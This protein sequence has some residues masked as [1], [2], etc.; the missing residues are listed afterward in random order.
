MRIL[1]MGLPGSGKTTLANR[2]ADKLGAT[3]LNADVIRKEYDDWDFSVE[4]RHRQAD[5]MYMLS[6]KACTKY[7]V[8]DFVCPLPECRK[9]I[10]AQ[11]VIW[12]NTIKEGRFDDTNQMFVQ[13]TE[14]EVD[15]TLSKY[16]TDADLEYVIKKLDRLSK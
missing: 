5:R 12:M 1:I 8:L 11:Y 10:D 9:K 13:P 15:L 6:R 7:V 16:C 4:G 2:L 3:W 14:D